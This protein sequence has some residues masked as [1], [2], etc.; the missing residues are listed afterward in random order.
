MA[1][2]LAE[3][4]KLVASLELQDKFS[5][6]ARGIEGSIGR[7]ETKVSTLGK[8]GGEASRGFKTAGANI[9]KFGLI[10]GTAAVGGLTY[11]VNAASDLSETQSKVGVVFGDSAQKVLDFG[12]TSAT[13]LGLSENAALSAAGTYGNLFVSMGLASDKSADMSTKLVTLAGD[14]ASFNNLDPDRG[15]GQAAG[16][17]DRRV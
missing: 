11:A 12:K 16:W 14:L 13:A 15:A 4:A 2:G 3:T 6:N 8:I 10:A 5:K 17:A 1:G 9:A 7:L